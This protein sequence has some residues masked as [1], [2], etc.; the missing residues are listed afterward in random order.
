MKKSVGKPR[1]NIQNKSDGEGYTADLLAKMIGCSKRTIYNM[2]EDGRVTVD[3]SKG[4]NLY[5]LNE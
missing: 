5:K 2:V 4:I 1:I 3:N